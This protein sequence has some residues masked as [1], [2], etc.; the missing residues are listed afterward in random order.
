M[1]EDR[2]QKAGDRAAIG[3][4]LTDKS[5]SGN[6]RRKLAPLTVQSYFSLRIH[7]ETCCIVSHLSESSSDS[8]RYF[9]TLNHRRIDRI[10]PDCRFYNFLTLEVVSE[11]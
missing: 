9:E 10:F 6:L 11:P 5:V 7:R 3:S 4:L 2:C 8:E 1:A